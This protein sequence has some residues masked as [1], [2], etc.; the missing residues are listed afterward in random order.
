VLHNVSRYF[1]N[2]YSQKYS[3]KNENSIIFSRIIYIFKIFKMVTRIDQYL[4]VDIIKQSYEADKA[5]NIYIEQYSRDSEKQRTAYERFSRNT[6]RHI[7]M[8]ED[9][10][11][12]DGDKI[13]KMVFDLWCDMSEDKQ[14]KFIDDTKRLEY[15]F[16]NVQS[17]LIMFQHNV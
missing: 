2:F 3:D 9:K 14:K 17:F 10:T 13:N 7:Y 15:L 8:N 1:R 5:W 16:E 11:K 12:I 6:K 4:F